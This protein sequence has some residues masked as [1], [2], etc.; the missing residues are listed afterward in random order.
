MCERGQRIWE[1]LK[2]SKDKEPEEGE[3]KAISLR[4]NCRPQR[5]QDKEFWGFRRWQGGRGATFLKKVKYW[6]TM[7]LNLAETELARRP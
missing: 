7:V 6:E 2:G 3:K 1:E 4:I 5:E